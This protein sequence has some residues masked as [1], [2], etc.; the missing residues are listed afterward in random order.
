M[1][2]TVRRVPPAS[3]SSSPRHPRAFSRIVSTAESVA[4]VAVSWIV[5]TNPSGSP[6]AWRSQSTITCSISV[7]AGE[8]CQISAFEAIALTSCSA[9]ML[10][11][12]ALAGK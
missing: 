10:A 12:A 11:G 9:S 5:P 8:V 6:T 3:P 7:A 1:R 2:S 4:T